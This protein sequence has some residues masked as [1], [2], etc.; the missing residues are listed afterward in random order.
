M[1]LGVQPGPRQ[2]P[3]TSAPLRQPLERELGPAPSAALVVTLAAALP[4]PASDCVLPYRVT[5]CLYESSDA[6]PSRLRWHL[7]PPLAV[8]LSGLPPQHTLLFLGSGIWDLFRGHPPSPPPTSFC[9]KP[10]LHLSKPPQRKPAVS[11]H[12][13]FP[14]C[15]VAQPLSI[16]D[17]AEAP[18]A[19]EGERSLIERT[20]EHE[21]RFQFHCKSN[22]LPS[23]SP[24]ST[25]H[26]FLP[27]RASRGQK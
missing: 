20:V 17:A 11:T 15:F 26:S 7:L 22:W 4:V 5:L 1:K 8:S 23:P 24:T 9:S 3:G 21:E 16:H 10:P 18:T 13:G 2:G 12:L 19:G 6:P 25:A 14:H 27:R